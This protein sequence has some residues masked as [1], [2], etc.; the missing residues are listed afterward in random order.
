MPN[1]AWLAFSERVSCEGSLPVDCVAIDWPLPAIELRR[2]A[3]RNAS[4]LADIAA[5]EERR[6][7]GADE[8]TPLMQEMIR[9][10]AKLSA[11]V[12]MVSRL[13][14]PAGGLPARHP[15]KFNATG[16]VLPASLV[17]DSDALLLRLYSDI[18]PSLPLELPATVMRRLDD[19]LV[20][21]A[22]AGLGEA[23][24]DALERFVFRLHRRK[25]AET[26]QFTP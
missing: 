9:L 18:C 21:V 19:E 20:F 17:P 7:E 15:V 2:L 6:V 4:V 14:Q 25:V 10:D 16:A 5:I 26:R 13:L 3:E 22:F 24:C 23:T 8:N 11:L 12:D 1:D